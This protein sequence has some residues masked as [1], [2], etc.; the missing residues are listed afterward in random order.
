MRHFAARRET[1]GAFSS[2]GSK[3]SA[4]ATIRTVT[5]LSEPGRIT[6]RPSLWVGGGSVSSSASA[7]TGA[8]SR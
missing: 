6:R 4:I 7:S 5:D 8:I 2:D 1:P 3:S